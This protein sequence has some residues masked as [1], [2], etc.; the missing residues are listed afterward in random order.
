MQ[1]RNLQMN[2]NV[3]WGDDKNVET[4]FYNE[5]NENPTHEITD[6]DHIVW[7]QDSGFIF[8]FFYKTGNYWKKTFPNISLHYNKYVYNIETVA[9]ENM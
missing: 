5:E 2:R 9:F 8:K 1:I 4:P 7:F 6:D 3:G